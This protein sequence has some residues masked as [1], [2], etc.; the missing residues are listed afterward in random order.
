MIETKKHDN[1]IK[2]SPLFCE[3]VVYYFSTSTGHLIEDN[4]FLS[5]QYSVIYGVIQKRTSKEVYPVCSHVFQ[6]ELFVNESEKGSEVSR[7]AFELHNPLLSV[8][9][10]NLHSLKCLHS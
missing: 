2:D 3:S 8:V 4:Y 7:S 10:Q 6:R 5:H 1:V 9:F